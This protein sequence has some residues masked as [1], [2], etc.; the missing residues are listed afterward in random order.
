MDRL[1]MSVAIL[2]MSA[3]FQWS[4]TTAGLVQYFFFPGLSSCSALQGCYLCL[5]RA[6]M[7]WIKTHECIRSSRKL[8]PTMEIYRTLQFPISD[9]S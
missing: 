4:P 2:P 9:L 1:N 6:D 8:G 3:D 7:V 5:L